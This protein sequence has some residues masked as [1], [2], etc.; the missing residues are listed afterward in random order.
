[1]EELAMFI[2]GI[3]LFQMYHGFLCLGVT[4]EN[5]DIRRLLYGEY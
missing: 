4:Y 5:D 1:M 3:V 2:M